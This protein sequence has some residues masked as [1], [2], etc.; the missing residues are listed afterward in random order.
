MAPVRDAWWGSTPANPGRRCLK[1]LALGSARVALSCV[2]TRVGCLADFYFADV[3]FAF[4]ALGVPSWTSP[5]S[6]LARFCDI[7]LDAW[8]RELP[9]SRGGRSG[10]SGA[11]YYWAPGTRCPCFCGTS[12][13][14]PRWRVA[15]CGSRGQAPGPTEHTG[16]TEHTRAPPHRGTSGIL[17]QHAGCGQSTS[18]SHRACGLHTACIKHSTHAGR[19]APLPRCPR[20]EARSAA[21]APAPRGSPRSYGARA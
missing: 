18:G 17:P 15:A 20:L 5:T 16:H 14:R 1:A 8:S 9:S 21:M 12:R 19:D 13:W 6:S 3:G 4:S 10:P 7:V 2:G 11:K